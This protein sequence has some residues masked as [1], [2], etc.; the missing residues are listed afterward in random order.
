MESPK[1]FKKTEI[2][3][4][5]REALSHLLEEIELPNMIISLESNFEEIRKAHNCIHEFIY[6]PHLCL[7]SKTKVSWHQKSAFLIYHSLA[8]DQAHRSFLEA[9]S[10]Y[11]NAGYILLR[12]VLELLLKGAFWECLAHKKFRDNAEIIKEK[13]STKIGHSRKTILDW[14]NDVIAQK[15][16]I[17]KELEEVSAGIFDKIGPIF[18][19]SKLRDLI[20]KP[21]VIIEQLAAWGILNSIP[22]PIDNVYKIYDDLSAEVHVIPDKTDIGR[23][24]LSQKDLFEIDVMPEELNKFMTI[25][26]QV[27]DIGIVIELNVLSDWIS[28][29]GKTKAKLKERLAVIENLE[30]KF[31]LEKLKSMV[32]L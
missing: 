2:S 22:N 13:A 25:L 8:F 26:H 31:S 28:W 17:E 14:L 27:V 4:I 11:Y 1:K 19:N 5:P 18:E 23:R 15:P 29:N 7:P 6:L 16:S 12:S 21:K 3:L 30:L 9:L 20:P 32:R 24:L 10:G